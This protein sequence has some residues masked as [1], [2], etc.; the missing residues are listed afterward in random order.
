MEQKS[1]KFNTKNIIS[2]NP[3]LD[4]IEMVEKFIKDNSGDFKKTE[5]FNKLPKKIMWG[6][7]NVILE[8]LWNNNRI[9]IDKEGYL[10]Y[11]WNPELAKK[12]INRK[13]F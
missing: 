5:L 13:G 9:G 6:T 12:F 3:R 2:R 11:I 10:I 8:Y 4:T 7:F 1:L